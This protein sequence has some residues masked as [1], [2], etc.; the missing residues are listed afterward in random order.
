MASHLCNHHVV[1]NLCENFV[2]LIS[3]FDEHQMNIVSALCSLF[4]GFIVEST[5]SEIANNIKRQST[6]G[7]LITQAES[8]FCCKVSAES[9][10][11]SFILLLS[12]IWVPDLAWHSSGK[13]EYLNKKL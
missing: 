8:C 10:Q 5:C 2:F 11:C 7:L 6:L 9:V 3:G 13:E 4:C 1:R 12:L